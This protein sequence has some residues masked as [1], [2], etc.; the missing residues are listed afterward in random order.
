LSSAGGYEAR[1]EGSL[2]KLDLCP[3]NWK[4]EA[5]NWN[6]PEQELEK[7]LFTRAECREGNKTRTEIPP[8]S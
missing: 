2:G 3:E 7:L 4:V 8:L 1:S 6:E 5:W